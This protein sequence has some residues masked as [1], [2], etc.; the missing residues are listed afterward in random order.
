MIT[1]VGCVH[2]GRAGFE[3]GWLQTLR[4][5]QALTSGDSPEVTAGPS[6]GRL[7]R[8]NCHSKENHALVK[9]PDWIADGVAVGLSQLNTFRHLF[10]TSLWL[11]MVEI[12]RATGARRFVYQICETVVKHGVPEF[13]K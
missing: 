13:K 6:L 1:V 5:T 9:R 12:V 11:A 3:P 10:R 2:K 8:E 4:I 7:S